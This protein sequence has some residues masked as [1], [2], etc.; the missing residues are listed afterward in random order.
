MTE[1]VLELSNLQFQRARLRLALDVELRGIV[2]AHGFS[3]AGKT[4]LLNLIAGFLHP[5]HGDI[6]FNQLS[7]LNM[8]V[9]QR[10]LA[11][12]FQH[13]T[14]FPHLSAHRNLTLALAAAAPRTSKKQRHHEAEHVLQQLHVHDCRNQKPHTLSG[15][16]LRRVA[17]ARSLALMP[18][19]KIILLDEPFNAVEQ[20]Q[21]LNLARVIA[22]SHQ[23]HNVTLITAHDPAEPH[24][25]ELNPRQ[26]VHI[27][28]HASSRE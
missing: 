1:S 9:S 22:Q 3:G 19:R 28:T 26:F 7:L 27:D 6:R 21:K 8:A 4:T 11:F 15:G 20:E 17:L 23:E 12:T 13:E 24:L 10:Q 14:L 25:L 16:Q 2:L 18:Y 5:Q